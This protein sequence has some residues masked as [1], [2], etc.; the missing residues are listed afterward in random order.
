MKEVFSAVIPHI[1]KFSFRINGH[2]ILSKSGWFI[3]DSNG[4]TGELVFRKGGELLL[5]HD[6]AIIDGTWEI[7]PE[8]EALLLNIQGEKKLYDATWGTPSMLFLKNHGAGEECILFEQSWLKEKRLIS[9]LVH[10]L[11]TIPL[12]TLKKNRIL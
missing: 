1:R 11:K 8:I 3:L 10:Y 2:A 9:A 7:V 6:E 4:A 5:I 12:I